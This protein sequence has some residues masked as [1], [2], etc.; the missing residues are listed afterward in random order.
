M[1][2]EKAVKRLGMIVATLVAIASAAWGA[3]PS[4]EFYKTQDSDAWV[5]HHFQVQTE[6][7]RVLVVT[8]GE[9]PEQVSIASLDLTGRAAAG[10]ARAY[11]PTAVFKTMQEAADAAEGGDLVVV[12]PGT[13]A[14]FLLGEKE[15]C[16]DGKFIHFKAYGKPGEVT[17][18]RPADGKDRN[19][20]VNFEAAHH[21]IL[22]GFNIAGATGP[23][24]EQK[25]PQAGIFINGNFG[26][27]REAGASHRDR[28]Q[29]LAQP[30]RLGPPF[31]G[32]AHGADAGELF[33][34]LR[35]GALGVRF[36][37]QRQLLHPQ[38]RLLRAAAQRP[39]VQPRSRRVVQR[40]R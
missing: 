6:Y 38:K 40:A 13:Y 9:A 36:R 17:I 12:M 24:L 21:A 37:R 11:K 2:K 10:E 14:G 26:E 1:R 34:A 32:H 39:P 33:R 15:S 28:Q 23:G 3:S 5:S 22:E 4:P 30:P 19:W 20:M 8:A 7:A 29:L 27:H 18:D 31:D 35:A 16:G 25:G